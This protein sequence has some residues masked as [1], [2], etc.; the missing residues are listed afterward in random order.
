MTALELKDV[1][2][3]FRTEAIHDVGV[4]RGWVCA[5]AG[6]EGLRLCRIQDGAFLH[7]ACENRLSGALLLT[8][9]H[10]FS[11]ACKGTPDPDASVLRLA[12][13]IR[14][15]E[16]ALDLV[17]LPHFSF[18]TEKSL[19]GLYGEGDL[20]RVGLGT[21]ASEM[22][23]SPFGQY[24]CGDLAVRG[25]ARAPRG[26]V[27]LSRHA[28]R[29][30]SLVDALPD[31]P[32]RPI[33]RAAVLPDRKYGDRLQGPAVAARWAHLA[34]PDEGCL[35]SL[36]LHNPE[37]R[38]EG[39]L[40]GELRGQEEILLAAAGGRVLAASREGVHLLAG[41]G[42]PARFSFPRDG[43]LHPAR[44]LVEERFALLSTRE[45]RLFLAE[46]EII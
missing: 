42:S 44:L 30:E 32:D 37:V 1:T 41:H 11:G 31:H 7:L 27:V 38:R 36:H 14:E 18:A 28:A 19:Y 40:P 9:G 16:A 5:A 46:I 39:P 24:R 2:P 25:I 17:R 3:L 23:A 35:L 26:A 29:P 13:F 20:R 34:S 15:T 10:V 43:G 45:G 4:S 6:E 21:G 22:P 8:G 33:A 12:P